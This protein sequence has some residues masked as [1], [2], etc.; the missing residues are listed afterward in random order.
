M[1]AEIAGLPGV[2]NGTVLTVGTFDGVH[3]GH[4][5]L[6]QQTTELAHRLG[7]ASAVVTFDPHPLDVVNPSASPP[8]LTDWNEKL[9]LF[10]QTSIDYLV[11]L[12]FTTQLSTLDAEAFV[13]SCVVNGRTTR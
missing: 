11:V 5:R 9:E 6:L 2:A 13:D 1:P 3:R 4:M 8:L 7:A 10:T 12:P